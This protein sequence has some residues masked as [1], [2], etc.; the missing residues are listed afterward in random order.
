MFLSKAVLTTPW[1]ACEDDSVLCQVLQ[2]VLED[3]EAITLYPRDRILHLVKR[4]VM[5]G[6]GKLLRILL[7]AVNPLPAARLSK[8]Y[9]VAA[10]ASKRIY[11]DDFLRRGSAG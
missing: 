7:Y 10:N 1:R 8:C 4:C 9:R 3:F 11:E 5:L 6:T 2:F